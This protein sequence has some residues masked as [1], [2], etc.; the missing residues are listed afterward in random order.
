MKIERV[1]Q[2]QIA[3]DRKQPSSLDNQHPIVDVSATEVS[4]TSQ[5]GPS[6]GSQTESKRPG[7]LWV[8]LLAGSFILI[9]I[10]SLIFV[11]HRA[12]G[13]ALMALGLVTA[14]TIELCGG[15]SE[16]LFRA[17]RKSSPDDKRGNQKSNSSVV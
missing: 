16:R 15:V 5:S 11:D 12:W 7:L 8:A 14:L 2:Q 9:P 10:G 3:E 13:C 1:N 4:L 17:V 6:V